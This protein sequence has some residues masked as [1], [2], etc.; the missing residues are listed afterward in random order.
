LTACS[1]DASRFSDVLGDA[2]INASQDV[3]SAASINQ[4]Y[5]GDVDQLTTASVSPQAQNVIRSQA[6][7]YNQIRVLKPGRIAPPAGVGNY[8]SQ[9][10]Q[11]MNSGY[12]SANQVRQNISISKPAYTKL[13]TVQS[14][15][16]SRFQSQIK[17]APLTKIAVSKP[18]IQA[19][20]TKYTASKGPIV[21][22][23]RNTQPANLRMASTDEITTGSIHRATTAD[24]EK[25]T[26]AAGWKG[27][28]GSWVNVKS[29]ETLYN[30]SRRYGVPVKDLMAANSMTSADGLSAGSKILIP[31]YT[32][33]RSSGVSAP[34][35]NPMTKASRASKGFFGDV[36]NGRVAIPT[37]RVMR[38]VKQ[39]LQASTKSETANRSHRVASGDTLYSV[40]RRYGVSTSSL[41]KS[42]SLTGT[43][44]RPGQNLIVP[45]APVAILMSRTLVGSKHDPIITGT[46]P[47]AKA[48]VGSA[49]SVLR[50]KPKFTSPDESLTIANRAAEQVKTPKKTSSGNFRWPTKGRVI[51]KFGQRVNGATNDGIDISVPI[52]SPVKATENGTVIYSGSELADFGNLIL[53]SHS[54]GWVSAYAHSSKNKVRRGDKV[55]RGQV[56]AISGK[57]GN[58]KRPKLHFELRKNS[59]PV[60]PLKHLGK[61]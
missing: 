4:A 27:A 60:N 13:S 26:P 23:P 55:T 57:S 20:V 3:A 17:S 31:A 7:G 32:Y 36:G 35:N 49:K 28:G 30:L 43:N 11:S 5:P 16:T 1:N 34:D 8:A 58:A 14:K 48:A 41:I 29:G 18:K 61:S 6:A 51:A 15:A 59:T 22:S 47:D 46:V 53:V 21:L 10:L 25:A 42:N 40:A 33:H 2:Q 44:I 37:A 9:Q 38:T 52:G 45:G 39:P 24:F 56:I 12:A 50:I 19:V 54:G